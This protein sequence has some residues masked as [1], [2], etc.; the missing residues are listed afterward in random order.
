MR[1]IHK[2]PLDSK[3]L[4]T[5]KINADAQILDV[6]IQNYRIV[7]WAIIDTEN[8]ILERAIT[9]VFT[10]QEYPTKITDKYIGTVQQNGLVVHIFDAGELR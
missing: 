9:A 3:M 7:L 5:I 8:Y 10:G 1:T 6:Q 2:F 4:Q